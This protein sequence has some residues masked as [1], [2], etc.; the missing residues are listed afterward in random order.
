MM[1]QF[2]LTF[3]LFLISAAPS[4]AETKFGLAMVGEPKYNAQDTHLDYANV[5]APKGGI[6]K[7]SA[8]GG[9]D[10]LNPYN[11]K[12]KAANGLNLVTDRLMARVWDE[13]FTMY[14]LIAKSVDVPE[15]RSSITFHL[16]SRAKFHDGSP[17]TADDVLFSFKTMREKGRPNQRRI[18]KLATA[19]KIGDNAVKFK[20]G[21]GYDRE[22][23]LIFALMPVISKAYWSEREFDKTTLEAPLGSGPYKITIAEAGKRIVLERVKDYWARDLLTN[24]GHHNFDKI[25]YDYYRDDTVAFESFK[26]GDLHLR[27]EWD[28]GTWNN[29]YNFPALSKGDVIK[30][31]IKHGRAAKVRGFIFNTRRAPFDDIKVRRALNIIF[32]FDWV[33]KNFFYD[34]YE[35]IGNSLLRTGTYFPNTD[36]SYILDTRMMKITTDRRLLL[37]E[38]NKMLNDAGWIIKDGK[39]MNKET[40]EPMSFEIL[41]DNPSDEKI[42]LA[43]AR[44]LKKMGIEP[45]VRILD[46]A[47][48]RGRMNNY[49]FDMTVYFWHSTLSPG[50][51]QY[52]YWS[53]ES[54]KTPSQWNYA[55]VCDPEIDTLA[56]SIPEAK[57]RVELI[58]KTRKLDQKL[59]SGTYMIPLYYNPQDYVAYWKMLKHPEITPLYG[60]VT[61]TWWMEQENAP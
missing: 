18:Y 46:S 53:C 30:Q 48:Y 29:S 11:I 36:L 55:G 47:A 54:A 49:D 37:K 52:L 41:L 50:T 7:Q 58:E 17:I 6:L 35:R 5:D 23:A 4:L 39:R 40:G 16:D 59:Q 10:T 34:K 3:T 14:P 61:E 22:T 45:N 20:F 15:D 19:T 8:I 42:A 33:N 60:I 31:E 27:R 26:A 28:A 9:F 24:K 21:E 38:A 12:G 2:F 57:T 32:D 25:I 44:N 43:Y 51:E 1:K 13:P 56:K